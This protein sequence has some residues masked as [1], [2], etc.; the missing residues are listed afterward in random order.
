MPRARLALAKGAH[1]QVHHKCVDVR[2]GKERGAYQHA[3]RD[4]EGTTSSCQKGVGRTGVIMEASTGIFGDSA[5]ASVSFIERL[6]D[7]LP[8]CVSGWSGLNAVACLHRISA[9]GAG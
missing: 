7:A 1:L 5:S 2:L 9:E 3:I 8:E 6:S 4:K